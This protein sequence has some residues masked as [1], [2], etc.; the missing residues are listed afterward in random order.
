MK[1]YKKN[2][3]VFMEFKKGEKAKVMFIGC[4]HIDN[5]HTDKRL[6]KRCL[7][8]AMKEDARIVFLGDMLD[9]MDSRNDPRRSYKTY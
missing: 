9:L 5:S 3:T 2:D 7:D 4:A 1:T 6:L 8:L